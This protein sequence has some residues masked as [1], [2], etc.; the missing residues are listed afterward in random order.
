MMWPMST[1]A[2]ISSWTSNVRT[3]AN[4]ANNRWANLEV[5]KP[6]DEIKCVLA[7]HA[8]F[9]WAAGVIRQHRLDRRFAVLLSCVFG[10][11][12]PAELAEWLLAS[13]LQARLQ[14]QMHKYIWDPATRGV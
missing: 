6:M 10:K 13:G 9:D 5:L 12:T 1:N 2:S 14:L 11:V 4:A 8:D 3:A 7:S